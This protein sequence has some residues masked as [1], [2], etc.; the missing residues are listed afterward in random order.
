MLVMQY[1]NGGSLHDYLQI[2]FS[3]IKWIEKLWIMSDIT[4]GY[5]YF[6]IY[7]LN[8]VHIN[9]YVCLLSII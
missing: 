1:V 2:H 5:L 9:N 7:H 6:L 8:T 3:D 4:Q